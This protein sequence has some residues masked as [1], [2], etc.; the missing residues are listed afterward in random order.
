MNPVRIGVLSDTH[1]TAM[2]DMVDLASFLC[3]GPFAD[4][5]LILHAGDIVDADFLTLFDP[6]PIFAVRG[7]CDPADDALPVQRIVPI[8]RFRLGLIHGWGQAST[9]ETTVHQQFHGAQVDAII[10]GHSHQPVCHERNGVL[11]FNPGSATDRRQADF[12]TVG[13]LVVT[14]GGINGEIL[15]LPW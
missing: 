14:D 9:I 7:N 8:D 3:A 15:S 11:F 13:K 10:Y 6:L 5:D 4:V 1:L 12:H 2:P